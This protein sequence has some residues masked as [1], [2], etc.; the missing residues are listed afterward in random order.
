MVAVKHIF[1]NTI[2]NT[3]GLQENCDFD[4]LCLQVSALHMVVG[5]LLLGGVVLVVGLVQLSPGAE[6]AA[7]RYYL[8]AVGAA[9]IFV[10]LILTALR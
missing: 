9:L 6:A 8:L 5:S 2:G 1:A 3:K 10:G 7:H 4:N